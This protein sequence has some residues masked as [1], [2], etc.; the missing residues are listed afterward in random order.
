LQARGPQTAGAFSAR[1]LEISGETEQGA[2]LPS[3]VSD[4]SEPKKGKRK[5][6]RQRA[7]GAGRPPKPTALHLLEGT[8]PSRPRTNEPKPDKLSALEIPGW[9]RTVKDGGTLKDGG[10]A[11]DFF[12]RVGAQLLKVGLLTEADACAFAVVAESYS[13]YRC[14]V[15]AK[16]KRI[17]YDRK[18][19]SPLAFAERRRALRD[20]HMGLAQFG[21]S[22]VARAKVAAG[23][24]VPLPPSIADAADS[25]D[26]GKAWLDRY[27]GQTAP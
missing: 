22:P 1:V 2:R 8:R 3:L 13:H 25:A 10:I 16:P 21:L 20:L 17:A 11:V 27:G 7:P 12:E 6:A 18:G 4:R 24:D 15:A 9:L 5:R 26:R 19:K 23:D 14:A